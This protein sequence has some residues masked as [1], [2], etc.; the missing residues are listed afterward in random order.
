LVLGLR[1]G[2]FETPIG[3][4]LRPSSSSIL[5]FKVFKKVIEVIIFLNGIFEVISFNYPCMIK[6]IEVI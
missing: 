5:G 3:T 1:Y 4:I 6:Y 2:W